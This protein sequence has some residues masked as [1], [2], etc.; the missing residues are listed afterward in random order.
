M[1]S[2]SY[3][4]IDHE[5]VSQ[6]IF[7]PR[8]E[9]MLP[10][11]DAACH[12]I[13]VEDS[14]SIDS[15]FHLA[16]PDEPHILFFHGNGEIASDYDDIGPQ[17]V[18]LGLSLLAVDYRGYGNSDG[19]PSASTMMS[20]AHAIFQYIKGWLDSE[21]RTGPLFV[22][23]RSLGSASA[24]EIA[25]SFKDEIRGLILESAFAETLPLLMTLGINIQELDISEKDG[26]N[27]VQK[28]EMVTMPVFMLHA[29]K[30]Q[31]L[32]IVNAELLHSRCT[33]RSKEL[34]IVPGADHNTIISI[35]GDLY[36]TV[37]KQFTNKVLKVNQRK[38]RR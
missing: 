7:H 36:F 25:S 33:V 28:I 26:F 9:S 20:D 19:T 30:D 5:D 8:K 1:Q 13:P 31:L 37:L 32:P 38:R 11:S 3:E 10:P 4:K 6:V 21:K 24:L 12:L 23:G 18:R 2:L 29:Q 34:S 35:A 15:R 22:M 16:K 14:I 27:N 17:Y